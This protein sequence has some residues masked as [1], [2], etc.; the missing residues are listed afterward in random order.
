M[1][2]S[3]E[4]SRTGS[5]HSWRYTDGISVAHPGRYFYLRGERENVLA[6]YPVAAHPA[7]PRTAD[8]RGGEGKR[9]IERKRSNSSAGGGKG[10]G[11]FQSRCSALS[12]RNVGAS[13]FKMQIRERRSGRKRRRKRKS[14]GWQVFYWGQLPLPQPPQSGRVGPRAMQRAAMPPHR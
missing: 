4:C 13:T 14:A 5:Q 6:R 12:V 7:N 10:G 9:R 2:S 8:E 1:K 11:G 3:G